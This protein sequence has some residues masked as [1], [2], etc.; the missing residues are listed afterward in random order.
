MN[1]LNE[2]SRVLKTERYDRKYGNT[3]KICV[4]L[5]TINVKLRVVVQTGRTESNLKMLQ[6][7]VYKLF[8]EYTIDLCSLKA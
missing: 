8:T 6:F 5:K 7:Y 1:V 2:L 4:L 3:V